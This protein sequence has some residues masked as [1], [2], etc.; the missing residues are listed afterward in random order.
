[1]VCKE[2]LAPVCQVGPGQPR[3]HAAR[4]NQRDRLGAE[5]FRGRVGHGKAVELRKTGKKTEQQ[6][7]ERQ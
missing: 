3:K 7:T 1:M 2:V 5:L 6:P 4:Q